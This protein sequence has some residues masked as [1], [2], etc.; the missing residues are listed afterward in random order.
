MTNK[1]ANLV[2]VNKIKDEYSKIN[3]GFDLVEADIDEVNAELDA[4]ITA[5]EELDVRVDTIIQGGGP[6]KD[7]ELVD[8]RTPDAS[9]TPETTI[10]VAG[11]MTRDMQAQ[12]MSHKADF[13]QAGL[14]IIKAVGEFYSGSDAWIAFRNTQYAGDDGTRFYLIPRAAVTTGVGGALKIFGDNYPDATSYRDLGIYFSADQSGDTGY[15]DTGAFWF[16]SKVEGV[17]YENLNPDMIFSFQDGAVIAGR[18]S[19]VERGGLYYPCWVIGSGTPEIAPLLESIRAEFQGD[20]GLQ[21]GR[22][23]RWLDNVGALNGRFGI[24]TNNYFNMSS[25]AGYKFS[26]ADVL[27]ATIDENQAKFDVPII[28]DNRLSVTT[29]VTSI[30]MTGKNRAVFNVGSAHTV[31]TITGVNGQRVT[32]LFR[33][34]NTTIA[35]NTVIKLTAGSSFVGAADKTLS[36]ENFDNVWYQV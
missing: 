24:D 23:F 30:D 29:T 4:E 2:A 6:D 25:P 14:D 18:I 8:I 5:R 13:T 36:L 31:S 11:D 1:Y 3:T 35:H 28:Q 7:A 34:G 17:D 15:N 26:V 20:A 27:K 21:N 10:V 33:N 19:Y 32:L 22:Y 12:F 16:N 9:Y